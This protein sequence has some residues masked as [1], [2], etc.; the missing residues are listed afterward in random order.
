MVPVS[1]E[2]IDRKIEFSALAWQE[3]TARMARAAMRAI[4]DILDPVRAAKRRIIR[5]ELVL[6]LRNLDE[7]Q[8]LAKRI[9]GEQEGRAQ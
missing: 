2:D 6:R 8:R 4:D 7:I 5:Q 3:E 1:W 9:Q